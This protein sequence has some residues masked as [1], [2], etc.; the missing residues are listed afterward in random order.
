MHAFS[1]TEIIIGEQGLQRLAGAKVAIFGV[2]GVGSYVAEALVRAGVGKFILV[3]DDTICLTNTNRQLHTTRK[4]IGQPK[5]EA[6]RQ[7]MLDINPAAVIET[8]QSFYLPE[9]AEQ[10]IQDDYD[11]IVDALDTVTA[12]I[13]LAVQ[14]KERSIPVISAMG[15]G[16]KLD[17][18]GFKVADLAKTSVCPLAKVM[19]KELRKRGVEHLKVVYSEEK[20]IVPICVETSDCSKHYICPPGSTKHCLERRS[21][22]GSISFVPGVVGLLIAGAVVNDL[23]AAEY[24]K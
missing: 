8:I 16:N 3:D 23:L 1:R 14:G 21:V 12:K 10:L 5:V 17:P 6:M 4:T 9:K 2:G 7:R 20:P 13:D 18:G 11:Y 15:A 19:R 24:K 22:P